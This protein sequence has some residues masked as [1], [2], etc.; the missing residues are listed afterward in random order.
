GNVFVS[1]TGARRASLWLKAQV[2]CGLK[3]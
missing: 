3:M 2:A 1:V